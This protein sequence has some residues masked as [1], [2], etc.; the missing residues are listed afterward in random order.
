MDFNKPIYAEIAND[1]KE[2]LKFQEYLQKNG[3]KFSES[4]ERPASYEDFRIFE[5]IMTRDQ[6]LAANM[7]NDNVLFYQ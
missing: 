6:L 7:A 4:T 1:E 5:C 2:V 3:I